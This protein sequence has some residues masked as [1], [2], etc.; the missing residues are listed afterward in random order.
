M[1][2]LE[3]KF[4]W[5]WN[6][7]TP[8]DIDVQYYWGEYGTLTIQRHYL[9]KIIYRW[10]FC[11]SRDGWIEESKTFELP[12]PTSDPYTFPIDVAFGYSLG[13]WLE[14]GADEYWG[15]KYK[16]ETMLYILS[17]RDEILDEEYPN[18][19]T[20]CFRR[21]DPSFNPNLHSGCNPPDVSCETGS[22]VCD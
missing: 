22:T 7:G 1:S 9:R 17:G 14:K 11:N 3:G 16:V 8:N 21:A 19:T 5:G 10:R 20:G 13:K 15:R 2:N 6:C 12:Q 4:H 18:T